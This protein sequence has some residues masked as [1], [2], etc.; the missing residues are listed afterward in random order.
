MST[1]VTLDE[2]EKCLILYTEC[3]RQD[4]KVYMKFPDALT[5]FN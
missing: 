2:I 3:K 5:C 1:I 4:T